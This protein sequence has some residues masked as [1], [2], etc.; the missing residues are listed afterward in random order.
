MCLVRH[1]LRKLIRTPMIW[2]FLLLCLLANL[3]F[4]C[5]DLY[6]R[7]GFHQTSQMVKQTG[8]RMGDSLTQILY[9]QPKSEWR[10]ILLEATANPK[11]IFEAFQMPQLSG[12][13]MPFAVP[14]PWLAAGSIRIPSTRP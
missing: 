8:Q 13:V 2:I 4:I 7:D 1:E 6:E 5:T 14:R 12:S 3:F 9:Q 10:D 11:D